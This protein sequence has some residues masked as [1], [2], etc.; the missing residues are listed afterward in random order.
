MQRSVKYY[1]RLYLRTMRSVK[2]EFKN[3]VFFLIY[4]L[5]GDLVLS[6][7]IYVLLFPKDKG[8]LK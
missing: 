3:T 6:W 4:S 1:Y 8:K 5:T 7:K 2:K